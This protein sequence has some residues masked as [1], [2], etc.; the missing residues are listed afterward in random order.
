MANSAVAGYE[1]IIDEMDKVIF[2]LNEKIDGLT[3][4]LVDVVSQRDNWKRRAIAA[5]RDE[6]GE[7]RMKERRRRAL[8]DHIV[9]M[10]RSWI[11][12]SPLRF[13]ETTDDEVV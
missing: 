8:R 4:S 1:R 10:E 11:E 6:H 7:D 9:S 12:S 13:Q 3:S 2:D 5:E